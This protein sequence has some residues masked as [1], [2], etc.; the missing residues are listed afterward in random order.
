MKPGAKPLFVV[1]AVLAVCGA[2]ITGLMLTGDD[3]NAPSA[4]QTVPVV[5]QKDLDAASAALAQDRG[6]ASAAVGQ[7]NDLLS[8]VAVVVPG[9]GRERALAL[10]TSFV[11]LRTNR[12]AQ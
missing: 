8:L 5:K 9:V 10:G 3:N 7:E 2:V 1:A 6:V 11:R 4:V 12:R